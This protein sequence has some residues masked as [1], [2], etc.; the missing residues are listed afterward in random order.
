MCADDTSKVEERCGK[1][2]VWF[3]AA[4]SIRSSY[5][6]VSVALEVPTRRDVKAHYRWAM[7][8]SV[9]LRVKAPT[10]FRALRLDGQNRLLTRS[11]SCSSFGAQNS[12][13]GFGR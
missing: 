2:S 10:V 5:H 11:G 7:P 3:H 13:A 1:K 12:L 9:T 6:T 4:L 8:V